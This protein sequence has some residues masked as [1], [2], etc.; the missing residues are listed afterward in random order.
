M[1]LQAAYDQARSYLEA[2]QIGQAISVAQHILK[3]FPENLE[4]HRIL[5]EAYL[6]GRQFDQADGAFSRVLRADPENI[7]AHVGLG[8]TFERQGKLA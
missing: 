5:G 4:A 6:A 2:N 8:I 3:H 1:S 7:Q